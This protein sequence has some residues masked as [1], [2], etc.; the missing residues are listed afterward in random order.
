MNLCG[1]GSPSAGLKAE[2][3]GQVN[4]ISHTYATALGSQYSQS[5]RVFVHEISGFGRGAGVQ[6]L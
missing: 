4:S 6:V 3:T 2:G 1:S 5:A